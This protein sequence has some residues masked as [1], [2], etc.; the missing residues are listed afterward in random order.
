MFD[1]PAALGLRYLGPR[2]PEGR[3]ADPWP[4][5]LPQN[6]PC[7]PTFHHYRQT[8]GSVSRQLDFVFASDPIADRVLTRAINGIDEWGPSDHC[9]VV[10]VVDE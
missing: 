9:R 8:P 1:R 3:Q 4:D 6:S 5:E 7:V 10:I 2:A